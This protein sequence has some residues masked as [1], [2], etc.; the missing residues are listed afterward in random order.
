MN[1]PLLRIPL[2]LL[3]LLALCA[4]A[5][6]KLPFA[7]ETFEIEGGKAFIIAA[8]KPAEGRPWVWYAPTMKSVSQKSLKFY[9]ETFT[10][11]GISV[12]GFDQGE[13]RG[14]PGSSAKF[15]A[16]HGEMVRRGW[17]P[18]PILLGQSRGGMMMLAWAMRNP[19]KVRAFVG[20]YPVCNLASWPLKSS[21]AQTLA[22]YGLPE[23]EFVSRLREFNPVDNLA[24]LM[25]AKVPMFVVHGDSDK[26]VPLDDNTRILKERYETGGGNITVKVIPGEG[27][28]ETASFFQCKELVDFVNAQAGK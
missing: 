12:A 16:F 5:D 13:V 1:L 3:S 8:P 14:A 19:D 20:I 15:T 21:K 7:R 6:E 11:A 24:G 2:A 23:A 10:N 25:A 26:V 4:A 9:F 28:Q 22:D 18:K 17:S 27:H